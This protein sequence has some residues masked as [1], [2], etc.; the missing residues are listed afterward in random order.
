[1][2]RSTLGVVSWFVVLL[3]LFAAS[4][5]ADWRP[6]IERQLGGGWH[7]N[8]YLLKKA[9]PDLP[10]HSV[11]KVYKTVLDNGQKRGLQE[12]SA[13]M[14]ATLRDNRALKANPAFQVGGRF[15][16]IIPDVMPLD[17]NRILL[18]FRTGVRIDQL[19]P[20]LRPYAK[21]QLDDAVHAARG[22][23]SHPDESEAN[24]LFDPQTGKLTGWP[25]P[26][27]GH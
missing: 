22:I 13:L 15:G 3:S 8:A 21:T 27:W 14:Q 24:F 19:A 6:E 7:S 20:A 25:D 23:I 26:G 1:M 16:N 18:T 9:R 10:N 11:M 12:I 5:R 2:P 17:A 4:A